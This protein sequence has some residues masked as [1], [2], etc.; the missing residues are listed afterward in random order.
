MPTN[1]D[2]VSQLPADFE[3]FGQAVDTSLADLKGGTTGQILSKTS[4]TDMDFTWVTSAGDIEGVTVTS[5]ITGGGTTGTV[6][7]GINDGTTA[8][9]GAVQ[10]ENS[11]SSTSTT[12][13]A[14]P[15]S[16]KSAYDLANAAIPKSLVDAAGDLLIGTAADTVGRLAIG[17]NGQFLQSNGTTAVWATPTATAENFALI[18][19]TSTTG[20]STITVSGISGKNNLLINLQGVSSSNANARFRLRLNT[21]TGSNYYW[22]GFIYNDGGSITADQG[23]PTTSVRV[24]DTGNNAANVV[25]GTINIQGAAGTGRKAIQLLTYANGG[26]GNMSFW[27]SGYYQGGSAISS[28]SLITDSGTFDAGTLEIYG[29]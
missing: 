11:T 1:T 17:T 4:N 6:T 15:A 26:G 28:V 2:L 3:V 18:S 13:A 8:Q 20:A 7:I 9:K 27:S 25:Q 23:W 19:A 5:P 10:L 16:V 24:G 22:F 14:V 29:G 12:T 21:D